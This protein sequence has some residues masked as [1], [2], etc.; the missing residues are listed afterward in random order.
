VVSNLRSLR[1]VYSS[2]RSH[3]LENAPDKTFSWSC[4][5]GFSTAMPYETVPE[6]QVTEIVD[7]VTGVCAPL[8]PTSHLFGIT[9]RTARPSNVAD[10]SLWVHFLLQ[11][12]GSSSC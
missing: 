4:L 2:M 11:A 3:H 8:D 12:N 6:V 5:V 1:Y 7:D 9:G 10:F